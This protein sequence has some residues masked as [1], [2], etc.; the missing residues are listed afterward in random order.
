[1]LKLQQKWTCGQSQL[2]WVGCSSPSVCLSVSLEH[3]SKRKDP[4]V[5]KDGIQNDLGISY[6][7]VLG[8][9]DQ[10]SR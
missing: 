3:N 7:M 1:M 8:L 2:T 10:R 6:A 9:K 5:F 4:K